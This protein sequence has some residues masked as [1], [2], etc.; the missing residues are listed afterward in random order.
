MAIDKCSYPE[1]YEY[2]L[3][4]GFSM[5]KIKVI[6]IGKDRRPMIFFGNLPIQGAE[7]LLKLSSTDHKK[8][9]ESF[10]DII[11]A[12]GVV[13]KIKSNVDCSSELKKRKNIIYT[14]LEMF[15][16]ENYESF[17]YLITPQIEGVFLDYVR[18]KDD[19]SVFGGVMEVAKRANEKDSFYEYPYFEYDFPE[20]RNAIAHGE[21]ID[22]RPEMAY[23]MIM[24]LLWITDKYMNC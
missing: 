19:R 20:K 9:L 16:N 11:L 14:A 12:N 13:K 5:E 3:D 18:L 4:Y 17:V 6:D 1:I 22:V 10:R 15:E 7:K 21:I 2:R 8:Y 24:V 23:E